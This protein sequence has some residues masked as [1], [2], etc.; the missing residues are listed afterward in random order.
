MGAVGKRD[1]WGGGG[2]VPK[3]KAQGTG[4][5]W[6]GAFLGKTRTRALHIR[7]YTRM[8]PPCAPAWGG[9]TA[10]GGFWRQLMY[11]PLLLGAAQGCW[12]PI[13]EGSGPPALV[14][15]I[16]RLQSRPRQP[17]GPART[18]WGW[19]GLGE[20]AG[21]RGGGWGEGERCPPN[22]LPAAGRYR[23]E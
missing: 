14:G 22:P 6:E 5:G 23:K 16:R 9:W 18:H 12:G 3:I 21:T 8:A 1:G 20:G 11:G 15:G 10:W 17:R 13:G 19:V 7:I 2:A 4:M